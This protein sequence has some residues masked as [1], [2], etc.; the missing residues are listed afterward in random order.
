M[1]L[2][3]LYIVSKTE[4]I[5]L[6]QYITRAASLTAIPNLSYHPT[7]VEIDLL[8]LALTKQYNVTSIFDAY[9]AATVLGARDIRAEGY[10]RYAERKAAEAGH[11][12]AELISSGAPASLEG[13]AAPLRQTGCGQVRELN[14]MPQCPV[15]HSMMVQHRLC[16]QSTF[17][18]APAGPFRFRIMGLDV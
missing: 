10:I 12:T 17:T 14:R 6:D 1:V 15:K 8:A 13:A 2:H 18:I 9:H 11:T 4:G 5:P 7:T 16:R 3:E